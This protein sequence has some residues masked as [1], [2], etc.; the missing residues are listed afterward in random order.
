M[1]VTTWHQLLVG[2]SVGNLVLYAWAI[3]FK[4]LPPTADPS[5]RALQTKMYVLAAPMVLQC[6]WR[7]VFPSLYLQRFTFYD[8]P[9]N[10][11]MVDRTLAC[12]GA[13][14]WNGALALCLA[15][16]DAELTGGRRWVRL[17]AWALFLTYV[18]AECFSYYNTA[19]TN[20]L[21]AAIEV[22]T[23]AVSQVMALPASLALASGLR[24]Q[25]RL[26]TT[27]G[28]F[29]LLFC[30]LA[31]VYPLYNFF[32]DVPMYMDRYRADQAAHKSYL[33]LL[34]GLRDAA[35]RRVP[36]Q[37]QE[38]WQDDM[39]WM[40]M[41]FVFNP[42]GSIALTTAPT[43]KAMHGHAAH[44]KSSRTAPQIKAEEQPKATAAERLLCPKLSVNAA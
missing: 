6:T 16:V 27:G 17:S 18:A 23:D 29:V 25:G 1:Q 5:R 35:T 8:T 4:R 38:D 7:S 44:G 33:P 12:A 9:L 43:I 28:T 22:G 15:H 21:W 32:I 3:A 42:L 40:V 19:T 10:S 26:R 41:Y 34:V 20:E 14:S 2:A 11:I 30:L 36:T 24:T 13:L 31:V 39:S 37:L